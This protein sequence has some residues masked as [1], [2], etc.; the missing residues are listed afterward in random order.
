VDKESTGEKMKMVMI[1]DERILE[2]EVKN[3]AEC[4]SCHPF[5][6]NPYLCVLVLLILI[7]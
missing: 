7:L 6:S 3:E 1:N 5:V 4:E 2:D